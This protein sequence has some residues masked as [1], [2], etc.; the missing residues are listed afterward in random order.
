MDNYD[1]R[2]NE[3][4]TDSDFKLQNKVK[5]RGD[6]INFKNSSLLL[7]EKECSFFQ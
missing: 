7:L 3:S 6:N 1:E 2:L 4:N 5:G